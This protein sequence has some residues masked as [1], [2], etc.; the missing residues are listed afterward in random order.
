MKKSLFIIGLLF[1]M[2]EAGFPQGYPGIYPIDDSFTRGLLRK[3]FD[4]PNE[5]ITFGT[6]WN[7][8]ANTYIET[9]IHKNRLNTISNLHFDIK[10]PDVLISEYHQRVRELDQQINSIITNNKARI[11]RDV[12]YVGESL[13]QIAKENNITTGN[14][15]ADWLIKEVFIGA[16]QENQKRKYEAKMEQIRY[17]AKVKLEQE[18]KKKM[19]P[20]KKSVLK[21]NNDL[22][23]KYLK[24][25]A[26]EVNQSKEQYFLDCY[27]FHKCF[28]KEVNEKYDYHNADWMNTGCRKPG[29]YYNSTLSKPDYCTVAFRKKDLYDKYGN[30]VFLEATNMFLEAG[31]AENN[32]NPRAYLLKTELEKDIIRKKFFIE[33]AYRLDE[34]NMQTIRARNYINERFTSE[35]FTAIRNGDVPFIDRSI[36]NGFHLGQ[37]RKGETPIEAAID[38]DQ[39]V[40]LQKFIQSI[41]DYQTFLKNNGYR[42]LFHAAAVDADGCISQLASLGVSLD[43]VDR[44]DKGLTALNIAVN[45]KNESAA[46]LLLPAYKDITPCLKYASLSGSKFLD[47]TALFIYNQSHDYASAISHY[48]P[49]FKANNYCSLEIHVSPKSAYVYVDGKFIGQGDVSDQELEVDKTHLLEIKRTGLQMVKTDI[50]PKKGYNLSITAV[51][52]PPDEKEISLK[53][54]YSDGYQLKSWQ[55]FYVEPENLKKEKKRNKDYNNALREAAREKA[56]AQADKYNEEIR[57][58]MVRVNESIKQKNRKIR[59]GNTEKDSKRSVK[60]SYVPFNPHKQKAAAKLIANSTVPKKI[61]HT[62]QA[63]KVNFSQVQKNNTV[64]TQ[65]N[66]LHGGADDNKKDYANF[67]I[68]GRTHSS[69]KHPFNKQIQANE[70][71]DREVSKE[72][73]QYM[74]PALDPTDTLP[75]ISNNYLG[76]VIRVT[77]NILYMGK[78]KGVN[79]RPGMK[80]TIYSAHSDATKSIAYGYVTFVN[81]ETITVEIQSA[82]KLL[83]PG[84]W[85]SIK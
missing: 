37:I 57:T 53:T 22:M 15:D 35:F 25:A 9:T 18:L 11:D 7:D 10:S 54:V 8:L 52:Q 45:N 74:I 49:A 31:L 64:N 1:L 78:A 84:D 12:R 27:A 70:D 14:S 29:I 50:V 56:Q 63:K 77:G 16:A 26:Y 55:D 32:K 82:H 65:D 61:F 28:I 83:E 85:I 17:E 24:A 76:T 81:N 71:P 20:I 34:N 38:Y 67:L 72:S 5:I 80:V 62:A 47:Q 19:D 2:G 39:P 42:L 6:Y 36:K 73:Q 60:I 66:R 4:I 46:R 79:L 3:C 69:K 43:Y 58:K 59:D 30:K 23:N 33:L 51:L 13:A 21:E 68:K 40:I 48:Y 41:P 75:K 44:H